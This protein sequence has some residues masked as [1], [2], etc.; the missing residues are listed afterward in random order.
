MKR[1]GY[2]TAAFITLI[3]AFAA[4]QTG[5]S[6]KLKVFQKGTPEELSL[7]KNMSV[8]YLENRIN[9]YGIKSVSELKVEGVQVDELSMAH[10]RVQQMVDGVPVF[11]S[12]AVVHL[13]SDGNVVSFTDNLLKNVQVDTT[14]V[15]NRKEAV[16]LAIAQ[17]GSDNLTSR[18][19][20]ELFVLRHE[21]QD[22]LVYR[23]ELRRE[24]GSAETSMPVYFIDAKSGEKVW[25]YDNL[26]TAV[27]TGS[28]LYSGTISGNAIFTTSG[29]S[30]GTY[31]MEDTGRRIGTF[32]YNNTT[33]SVSRF[34]D[35]DN[36]WNATAQRA[37]VDAHIGASLAFDYYLN[38]HNR[39]G[40]DGNGGPAFY[41][42]A[43]GGVGLISSRIHYSRNYNNAFWNGQNMTYG[44]G[45]GTNFTPLTTIDICGHELTHGVTERTARLVYSGQSGALNESMSDIFGSMIER[46]AYGPSYAGIWKIGEQAFTPANGTSDALRYMDNPHAA[47]NSGFT[48]DD[49]PDHFAERYTGT[50]DNGGVHIN[51]GIP[52]KVFFLLSQGGTHHRG[53]TVTGIGADAAARIFYR[54][55]TVYMTSSTQ[56]SGART[57][58]LNA[59]RDLFGTG[60][61]Q[62]NST[63][64]AWSVCGVN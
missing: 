40:I 23:V 21:G 35:A 37:G 55:L 8:S 30:A 33:T 10:T 63:A 29:P 31:Y 50:A 19:K 64:A 1:F 41:T 16:Q 32:N 11:G 52:N 26:Q 48:A 38:V 54:A 39:R 49:D 53:G 20:A 2:F 17:F 57:A 34:T 6:A 51:S 9:E 15:L 25:S 13:G 45:D 56:F 14:P 7:A 12:E 43:I 59:A 22:R 42:S 62:Q 60:S 3:F 58:T 4:L 28:S 46:F 5:S 24:D 47:G 61:A 44:D 27:G 36:N 18:P